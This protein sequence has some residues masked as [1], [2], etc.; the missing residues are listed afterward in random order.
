MKKNNIIWLY[1]L[2]GLISGI[3][4]YLLYPVYH[5]N[6]SI[7]PQM[8]VREIKA[9]T[10]ALLREQDVKVDKEAL[11]VYVAKNQGLIKDVQKK[12][13][14]KKGNILL[15]DFL[16]AYYFE[17]NLMR[18]TE[19]TF[20]SDSNRKD[21]REGDDKAP[22]TN[23]VNFDFRGKIIHFSSTSADSS[24][25]PALTPDEA[26]MKALDFAKKYT[27]VYELIKNEN[28]KDTTIT[29][30]NEENSGRVNYVKNTHKFYWEVKD[31]NNQAVYKISANV[32]GSHISLFNID[33]SVK[34]SGSQS[35]DN[36]VISILLVIIYL[37]VIIAVGIS[38]YRKI[39]A[40]EIGFKNALLMG[41]MAGLSFSVYII[42][43]MG[44]DFKSEALI[45][46][47]AVFLFWGGV[48][49]VIWAVSEAVIREL[50]KEKFHTFDIIMKGDFLN[51]KIGMNVLIGGC[52]GL[53]LLAAYL[54]IIGIIDSFVNIQIL[55]NDEVLRMFANKY[56]F[57][58][59]LNFDLHFAAF[60][61]MLFIG[62]VF[63]MLNKK[64]LRN[65]GASVF[66][67]IIW[68]FVHKDAVTPQYYSILVYIFLGV[69]IL[70]VFLKHDVFTA[71]LAMCFFAFTSNY[72]SVFFTGQGSHVHYHIIPLVAVIIILLYAVTS[73]STRDFITDL[74]AIMPVYAVHITERQRL[75]RELEIAS[76]VQMSFL[77]RKNPEFYGL[78]IS[79]KCVPAM[80]VGGDYFDFIE[81]DNDRLGVVMGDVSGKGTQA[82]FYMT[83]SKGFL[84]A[85]AKTSSS[86]KE[87]LIKMN[88][89][90]YEN[91][92]R[93]NFI[94][95]FIGVFDLKN[96]SFTYSSAG[97]NPL[98]YAGN[99]KKE[100]IFLPSKGLALG[101][102]KGEIFAKTITENTI[103]FNSEDVFILYTDGFTEAMNKKRE[104]FGSERLIEN[105]TGLKNISSDEILE[106]YFNIVNNHIG[107]AI[108]HDDMSM[109]VVKIR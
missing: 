17:V 80:E 70:Y 60:Y 93:G 101:L 29:K 64:Y 96:N 9:K 103:E 5:P 82:A 39:R 55:P 66:T 41:L 72:L 100:P 69:I 16:P 3:I 35:D 54:S 53:M 71:I 49:F 87:V 36:T 73:I 63:T 30:Y 85:I 84:K 76:E 45:P 47:I 65:L 97:H 27:A 48:I 24:D 46:V 102:E 74:N 12:Y 34:T 15:R 109:V 106:S 107:K 75:Q 10:A 44:S 18:E 88:N 43:Q 92:D 78:D 28:S 6:S 99:N 68:G 31:N 81:F 25:S 38:G 26:K 77:P 108:Q 58:Y 89:M 37:I 7:K 20:S 13:G 57:M 67:V 61:F 98:I 52:F 105:I 8:G 33:Y 22:G 95:M 59:F 79:S 91:V 83:L 23:I 32:T 11:N 42:M 62:F 94:T 50:W 104:E 86:P 40:F 19:V 51:S 21:K 90:F 56:V 14:L 2:L 4:I 1:L